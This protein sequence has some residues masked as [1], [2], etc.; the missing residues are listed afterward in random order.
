MQ[1]YEI[2]DTTSFTRNSALQEGVINIHT[3]TFNLSLAHIVDWIDNFAQLL[4]RCYTWQ[5][6]M[7]QSL[8]IRETNFTG[9]SASSNGPEPW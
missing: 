4:W 7:M 6:L 1:S 3:A 2:Q 5:G 8:E 9:N